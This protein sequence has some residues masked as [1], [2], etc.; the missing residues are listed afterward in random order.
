MV[1]GSGHQVRHWIRPSLPAPGD[2]NHT[3]EVFYSSFRENPLALLILFGFRL[4]LSWC[5]SLY[6]QSVCLLAGIKSV[7]TELSIPLNVR[8]I[9]RPFL[10]FLFCFVVYLFIKFKKKIIF[11][12]FN[13][14]IFSVRSPLFH[15]I[16]YSP[17]II[18]KIFV[19]CYSHPLAW[20]W[21]WPAN[22]VRS[23][24]DFPSVICSCLVPRLCWS[25]SL[26]GPI[27]TTTVPSCPLLPR[28]LTSS[29]PIIPPAKSK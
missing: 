9:Q 4:S 27:A 17:W 22:S 1:R 24:H 6:V 2:R 12:F 16:Y 15:L 23:A 29:I 28:I 14:E 25:L 19:Y 21:S 10:S 11:Y 3:H 13:R 26:T 7:L 18:A 20:W 5:S 8:K